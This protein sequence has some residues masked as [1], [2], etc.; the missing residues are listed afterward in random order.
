M[1]MAI[2]IEMFRRHAEHYTR[3]AEAADAGLAGPD[4]VEWRKRVHLELDNL[5][6]RVHP[7]PAAG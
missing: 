1:P 7:L 5:R 4:E 6:G 3:F 2:S